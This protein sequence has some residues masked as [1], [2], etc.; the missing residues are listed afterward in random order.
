MQEQLISFKVA[1]LV[2]DKGMN[3]RTAYINIKNYDSRKIKKFMALN[4]YMVKWR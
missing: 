2:K 4:I 1:K 3:S